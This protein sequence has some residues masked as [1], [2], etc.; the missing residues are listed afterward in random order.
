[1]TLAAPIEDFLEAV[2]SQLDKTQDRLRLKAVNRPLTF[3]LKDFAI[4]LSVF[5][6]LDGEG[7]I[8]LR[9]AGPNEHGAST[10]NISF[11]TITRPMIEEN[12]IS[13]ELTQSP[14]LE[15]MGLAPEESKQLARVG[16]HNQAQLEKLR[17]R[18]DEQ[19]VARFSGVDVGRLR[20]AM[21]TRRPRIDYVQIGNRGPGTP[22]V[23]GPGGATPRL[24]LRPGQSQIRLRGQELQTDGVTLRASLDGRELPVTAASLTH[25]DIALPESTSGRLHVELPDGSHSDFDLDYE[26]DAAPDSAT[27]AAEV[28]P[29]AD[30][31]ALARES[32]G[33]ANGEGWE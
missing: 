20:R 1:M 6:E 15:E 29:G 14:S 22:N 19:S 25:A 28:R 4:D 7:L 33:N 27:R 24:Q 9:P 13:M 3:A 5:V 21:Q 11:T 17:E 31:P 32:S 16:V 18:T 2:T 26:A 8:R 10:I 12:T 30:L 23:P